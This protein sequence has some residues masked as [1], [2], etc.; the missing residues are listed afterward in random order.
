MRRRT[1]PPAL[2]V[3]IVAAAGLAAA[4]GGASLAPKELMQAVLTSIRRDVAGRNWSS[5]WR[6]A[7][8][9]ERY[10]EIHRR[11]HPGLKASVIRDFR[12]NLRKLRQHIRLRQPA[13]CYLVIGTLRT[14]VRFLR[15]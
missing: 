13:G 11:S 10:W 12:K 6:R 4:K 2:V 7:G 1:L 3:L 15:V 5:A 8:Q 14:M 9:F